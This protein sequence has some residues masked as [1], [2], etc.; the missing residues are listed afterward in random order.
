MKVSLR[1]DVVGNGSL[2]ST[3]GM[4]GRTLVPRRQVQVVAQRKKLSPTNAVAL[5]ASPAKRAHMN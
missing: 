2:N 1:I 5:G 3:E 4:K